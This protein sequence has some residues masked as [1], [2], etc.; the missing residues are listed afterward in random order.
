MLTIGQS[1][2][3]INDIPTVDEL[4]KRMVKEATDTLKTTLAK[5]EG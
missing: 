4:I 3:R 2:G 5:I 1:V